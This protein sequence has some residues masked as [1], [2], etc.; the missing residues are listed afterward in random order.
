MKTRLKPASKLRT[1]IWQAVTTTYIPLH[2]LF[3]VIFFFLLLPPAP[4]HHTLNSIVVV[5]GTKV[6]HSPAHEKRSTQAKPSLF[7]SEENRIHAC[8]LKCQ[9]V[10]TTWLW[11]TEGQQNKSH[12]VSAHLDITASRATT[13]NAGNIHLKCRVKFPKLF[14]FEKLKWDDIRFGEKGEETPRSNRWF[15]MP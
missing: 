13:P 6:F 1:P 2:S 5:L 14:G 15:A 9:R 10:K 4:H 7:C 11:H 12:T 3:A 8:C